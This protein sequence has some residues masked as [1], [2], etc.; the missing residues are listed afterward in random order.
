VKI[1][2]KTDNIRIRIATVALCIFFLLSFDCFSQTSEKAFQI[3]TKDSVPIPDAI[4]KVYFENSEAQLI[5]DSLGKFALKEEEIKNVKKIEI[6][7]LNFEGKVI[8]ISAPEKIVLSERAYLLDVT[9]VSAKIKTVGEP[10]SAN[11]GFNDIVVNFIPGT[12]NENKIIKKLKY[13]TVNFGGVKG[14]KYLPFKANLYLVDSLTGLPGKQLIPDGILLKRSNNKRYV[15]A[16]ISNYNIVMPENGIFI[17]FELLPEESYKV[18]LIQSRYGAISAVPALK[19]RI[20][21]SKKVKSYILY[22][23]ERLDG[24]NSWERQRGTYDMAIEF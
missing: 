21:R 24:K 1:R 19:I 13:N 3:I 11:F 17:A 23:Y 15:E 9:T 12:K 10:T 8:K 22:P 4:I 2:I 6:S 14:L 5:S 7:H 16:D 18:K 20:I